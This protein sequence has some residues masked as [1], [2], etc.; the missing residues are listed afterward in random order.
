MDAMEAIHTR[1]SIR[2]YRDRPV[3]ETLIKAVLAA[4]MDAPSACNAQPGIS[5]QSP[6]LRAR[7]I[8]R[9]PNGDSTVYSTHHPLSVAGSRR[10]AYSASCRRLWLVQT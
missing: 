5:W 3:P 9:Q 7:W 6:T 2:K 4:A 8:K 10:Y 1:R